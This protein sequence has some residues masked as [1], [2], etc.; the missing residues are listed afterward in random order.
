[1]IVQFP[2]FGAILKH[3]PFYNLT[4]TMQ[5]SQFPTSSSILP[6][7]SLVITVNQLFKHLTDLYSFKFHNNSRKQRDIY[8]LHM[9]KMRFIRQVEIT[10]QVIGSQAPDVGCSVY[11]CGQQHCLSWEGNKQR[12]FHWLGISISD[13]LQAL[14]WK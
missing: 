14:C 13:V 12:A 4:K 9:R 3:T 5:M 6:M 2:V 1:M 8:S 10:A 7:S 11:A